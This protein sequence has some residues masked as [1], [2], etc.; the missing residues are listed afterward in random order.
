[1]ACKRVNCSKLAKISKIKDKPKS[2]LAWTPAGKGVGVGLCPVEEQRPP[3]RTVPSSRKPPPKETTAWIRFNTHMED[4]GRQC[5]QP[6]KSLDSLAYSL[7]W[8][9]QAVWAG[10]PLDSCPSVRRSEL[11]TL[12]ESHQTRCL[13]WSSPSLV[14]NSEGGWTWLAGLKIQHLILVR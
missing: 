4:I 3:W 8:S 14:T 9:I 2:V 5:T 7:A 6:Q 11:K 12:S 13:W 1:M 10:H